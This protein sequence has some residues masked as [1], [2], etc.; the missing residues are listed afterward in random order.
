[1]NTLQ[2]VVVDAHLTVNCV[3]PGTRSCHCTSLYRR[4]SLPLVQPEV[5][6]FAT[7]S[8]P[9]E[10]LIVRLGTAQRFQRDLLRAEKSNMAD[11]MSVTDSVNEISNELALRLA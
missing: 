4:L 10:D 8:I 1:M 2:Q 5:E 9:T 6:N 3:P 11:V 7:E